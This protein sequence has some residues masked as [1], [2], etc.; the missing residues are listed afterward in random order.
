MTH[1]MIRADLERMLDAL[2]NIGEF[3]AACFVSMAIDALGGTTGATIADAHPS[4]DAQP[5]TPSPQPETQ[6]HRRS[7]RQRAPIAKPKPRASDS[8]PA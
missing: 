8:P 5:A 2:D 4:G 1:S 3:G 6:A 7:P